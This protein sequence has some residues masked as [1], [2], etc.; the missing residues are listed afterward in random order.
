MEAE[1]AEIAV[2]V[3]EFVAAFNTA[4]GNQDVDGLA[5]RYAE[6]A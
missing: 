1:D 5:N 4:G 3:K 2:V 6:L